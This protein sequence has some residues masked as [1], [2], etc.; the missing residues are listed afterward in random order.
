MLKQFYTGA[1][2]ERAGLGTVNGRRWMTDQFFHILD[3]MSFAPRLV[4][5]FGRKRDAAF[6]NQAMR[7]DIPQFV[8]RRNDGDAAS[9]MGG[10]GED[11]VGAKKPGGVHHDF[12][13]SRGFVEVIAAD[14]MDAGRD[15]GDDRGVVH[16]GER[17]HGAPREPAIAVDGKLLE[18]RH[19]SANE[20]SIKVFVGR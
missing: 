5:L 17:R 14:S 2:E 11:R 12:L 15:A 7:E 20:R 19:S 8:F 18:M 13:T 10:S 1:Q 16:V 6:F 3:A 4:R 9:G